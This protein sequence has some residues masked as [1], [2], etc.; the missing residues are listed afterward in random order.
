MEAPSPK[1]APSPQSPSE[2]SPRNRRKTA[3]AIAVVAVVAG[4]VLAL[5]AGHIGPFAQPSS[6]TPTR[7]TMQGVSVTFVG[8]ATSDFEFS[9][10]C[11]T[12]CG[13]GP[14][15]STILAPVELG[16]ITPDTSC[17]PAYEISKIVAA[18]SGAF[19]ITQI[20]DTTNGTNPTFG[21]PVFVPGSQGGDSC[22]GAA[23]LSVGVTIVGQGPTTQTLYLT[24]TVSTY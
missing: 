9:D 21:L 11:T 22:I 1:P 13:A 18:Q 3:T 2:K 15:N 7:Y 20:E 5:Y 17:T 4:V 19:L 6:S 8:N 24:A 23:Y 16:L 12:V 14:V 10:G